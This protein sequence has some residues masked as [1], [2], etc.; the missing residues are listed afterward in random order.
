MTKLIL[1]FFWCAALL[2]ASPSTVVHPAPKEPVYLNAS[3]YGAFK[4]RLPPPPSLK[5]KEQQQ[6]EK[7]LVKAQKSRT[8]AQCKHAEKEVFVSLDN[9]FGG[10]TGLVKADRVSELTP[11]FEQLRNDG[12]YFIQR[13]KKDFPRKRPFAYVAGLTPCV[14]KE[15]TGAYPS[16]HAVLSKLYALVLSEMSPKD[17]DKFEA[18]AFEI[19]N[20]RVLT[21]MHHPSDIAAGRAL[22]DLIY[23][24]L[25]KSKKYQDDM[26]QLAAKGSSW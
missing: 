25:K 16:G 1:V 14:P 11:F 10:A 17:R 5:S 4:K 22:A 3:L 6:D 7:E 19:A 23:E 20:H 24:E 13:L 15:V 21:G 18:R 12:D 26:K 2:A 9:F 8:E